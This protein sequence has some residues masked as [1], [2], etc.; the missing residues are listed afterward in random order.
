[1]NYYKIY[2]NHGK[3]YGHEVYYKNPMNVTNIAREAVRDG[4]LLAA[5]YSSVNKI[6]KIS[7]EEYHR[8]MWD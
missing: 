2:V 3:C 5:F 7:E 6:D 4:D 1:M 8:Y